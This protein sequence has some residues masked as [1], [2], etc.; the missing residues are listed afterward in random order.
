MSV[1]LIHNPLITSGQSREEIQ[2][3]LNMEDNNFLAIY[4]SYN[5]NNLLAAAFAVESDMIFAH[6]RVY[7]RT[8]LGG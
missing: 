1:A 4:Q 8:F 2:T 6:T 5:K 7:T 3:A